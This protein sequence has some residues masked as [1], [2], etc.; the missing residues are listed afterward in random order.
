MQRDISITGNDESCQDNDD[1]VKD[2]ESDNEIG[3]DDLYVI[4]GTTLKDYGV[5]DVLYEGCPISLSTCMLLIYTFG[6]RH[7]LT[8]EALNDMVYLINLICRRPNFAPRTLRDV[9]KYF[10]LREKTSFKKHF[11]CT[12]CFVNLKEESNLYCEECDKTCNPITDYHIHLPVTEQLERLIKS[13]F[14]CFIQC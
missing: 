2:D 6:I 14:N 1:I 12:S 11:F 10:N 7:K 8:K 4:S 3:D 13:K 5:E 9:K